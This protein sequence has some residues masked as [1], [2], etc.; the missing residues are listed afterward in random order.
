MKME[1]NRE[2][3]TA[4]WAGKPMVVKR[5]ITSTGPPAPEAAQTAP[6]ERPR[7]RYRA[8]LL[9]VPAAGAGRSAGVVAAMVSAPGVFDALSTAAF[10]LRAR[11]SRTRIEAPD[12]STT[13]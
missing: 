11:Y 8:A 3:P 7:R 9:A 2:I 10:P 1:S 5:G 13:R 12:R 4:M 6:V